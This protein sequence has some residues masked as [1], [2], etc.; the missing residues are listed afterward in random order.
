MWPLLLLLPDAAHYQGHP[1]VPP[2]TCGL[3]CQGR[4]TRALNV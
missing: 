1:A 3:M 2:G 4:G